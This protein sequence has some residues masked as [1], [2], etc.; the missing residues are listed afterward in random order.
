LTRNWARAHAV[1]TTL[2]IGAFVCAVAASN[3]AAKKK[4]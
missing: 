3:I 1:R 4:G 2:G